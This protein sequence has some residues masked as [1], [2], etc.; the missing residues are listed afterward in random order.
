VSL[1]VLADEIMAIR[2]G[3]HRLPTVCI[4]DDDD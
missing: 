1:A 2:S 3:G 4:E